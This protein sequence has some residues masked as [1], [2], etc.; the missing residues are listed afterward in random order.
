[1]SS[2]DYDRQAADPSSSDYDAASWRG[3]PGGIS[4][5]LSSCGLETLTIIEVRPVLSVV[6]WRPGRTKMVESWRV[7]G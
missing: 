5:V 4:A 2:S 3:G 7:D 6:L 1:M